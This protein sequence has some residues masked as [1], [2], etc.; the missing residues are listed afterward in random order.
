MWKTGAIRR[1]FNSPNSGSGVDVTS[2]NAHWRW[3][4]L[5]SVLIL[6][7]TGVARLS[8]GN[9]ATQFN[10]MLVMVVVCTL[11][12]LW[13]GLDRGWNTLCTAHLLCVLIAVRVAAMYVEPLLEDDHFRYLWDG[14]IAATTGRPFAY[15]PSHFFQ[16]A[17]VP[18]AMQEV[19]SGINNPH[20]PTIYGPLLQAVFALCYFVAPAEL[21]PLKCVLLIA[22]I[23]ILLVLLRAGVSARWLMLWV[24]HPLVVKESAI[25]AHPDILLGAMLFAAVM[26]WRSARDSSA[27]AWASAAVAIKV[28]AVVALPLFWIN[29]EGRFSVRGFL[30]TL[31]ALCVFYGPLWLLTSGAEARALVVFGEQWTFNPLLFRAVSA[32]VADSVARSLVVVIFVVAWFCFVVRWIISL[33]NTRRVG[34][35]AEVST[36]SRFTAPPIVAIIVTLLVLSPTINPWY[37]LWVLPLALWLLIA[38]T[39]NDVVASSTAWVAAS[40]SLLAYT[41]VAAQVRVESSITTFAVPLWATLLQCAVIVATLIFVIARARNAGTL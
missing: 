38:G 19:L 34:L 11:A 24:L 9:V 20:I 40:A 18:T 31:A 2:W 3:L 6:M 17:T 14:F 13:V 16:S 7:L 12:M 25:T 26:C 10:A 8:H 33:R 35:A 5:I 30:T 23:V 39:S 29:R 21:W 28:S 32:I 1:V 22:E 27:A 41:H 37:W 4:L 36:D 15:A